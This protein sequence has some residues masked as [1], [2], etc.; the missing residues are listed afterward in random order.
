MKRVAKWTG[1]IVAVFLLLGVALYLARPLYLDR[2]YYEGPRSGHYDGERF[3][4]PEGDLHTGIPRKFAWGRVWGMVTGQPAVGWPAEIKV[5]PTRPPARVEG[6]AMRL[7]WIGHATVLVQ[8]QGLNIL[9]DPI[10]S[11]VAGPWNLL[12]PR[13]AREPGV[14]FADLPKIDLVLIS[15]NHYDHMDLP[16][17]DRLWARDKPLIVTSLGNDHILEG[18]G[19][20]AVAQDW[21]GAVRVKPGIWVIVER[22]H[23]WGSRW[24]QDRNRALWSGFTITLPHGNIFFAGDTG[25]GDGA[26]A[27]EAARH[28]PF[29]LAILP[30]GAYHP[31]EVF[32]GNHIDPQQA[33]GVF[34][35]LGAKRG[36][37]IHWGTFRLT[38]EAADHPP[39]EMAETVKAAGMLASRFVTTQPGQGWMVP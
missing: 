24:G 32:A 16:T 27:R 9:T 26:W 34:R 38:D 4:N 29:R 2:I 5:N 22:V 6:P 12:G 8:T 10:W 15:H 14:R 1:G 37:G 33:L 30:I 7:T 13:R 39:V 3:F 18:R 11:D 23:H 31:R 19:I 21:G 28:G 35:T 17:L 25:F 36:F 20:A